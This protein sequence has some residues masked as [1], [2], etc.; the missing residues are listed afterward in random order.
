MFITTWHSGN[1]TQRVESLAFDTIE[2]AEAEQRLPDGA[3]VYEVAG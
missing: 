2:A 1:L 3:V